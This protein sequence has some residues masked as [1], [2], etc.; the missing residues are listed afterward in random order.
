MGCNYNVQWRERFCLF[1]VWE[2][3]CCRNAF[4]KF[5]MWGG[6]VGEGRVFFFVL[7]RGIWYVEGV[8]GIF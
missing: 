2:G 1:F 7:G 8:R 6:D 3:D 5:V 4:D